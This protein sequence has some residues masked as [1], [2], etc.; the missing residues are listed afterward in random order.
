MPTVTTIPKYIPISQAAAKL[1]IMPAKLHD[2]AALGKIKAIRLP[3]GGLAVDEKLTETPL[4]KEDLE[5]YKQFAH[6]ANETTWV[7]KAARD[8]DVS[9]PTISRWTDYGFINIEGMNGNKKLLNAQD[10]AYCAFVYQEFQKEG[11]TQGRRIFD[12]N[13]M[14]YKPKTGPFA[15]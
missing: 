14:P 2:M 12:D 7:S 8:Y 3:N 10:V 13:G 4:R 1:G 6:L 5:E 9:Q 11:D 15:E